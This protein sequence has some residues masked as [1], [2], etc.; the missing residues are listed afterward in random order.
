MA[1]KFTTLSPSDVAALPWESLGSIDGAHNKV[2][3][4]DDTSMAGVL[5][6]DGGHRLGA[7]THRVNH[8]HV[9]V[10]EGRAKVVGDELGPGSYAHVPAGVEH[11]IDA[12]GTDGCTVFYLYIRPDTASS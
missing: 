3:W 2:L 9:W 10:L 6:V 11:D 12:S 1:T 7:H 5:R 8:H 4:R